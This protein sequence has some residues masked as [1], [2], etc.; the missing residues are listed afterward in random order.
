VD[1]LRTNFTGNIVLIPQSQ[2]GA[3]ENTDILMRKLGP[4]SKTEL[5]LQEDDFL[6][7]ANVVVMKGQVKFIDVDNKYLTLTGNN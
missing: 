5:Y 7:K 1:A 2:F 3:F 4:L 6:D